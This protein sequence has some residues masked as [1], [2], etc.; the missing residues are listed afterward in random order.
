MLLIITW[1]CHIHACIQG[2]Q[3]A[4]A[5]QTHG[6]LIALTMLGFCMQDDIDE[7]NKIAHSLKARLDNLARMN[8]AA[9]KRKV[10]LCTLPC[11]SLELQLLP[12]GG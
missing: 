3:H 10:C 1:I 7:V 4:L 5:L 12:K 9:L 2:V 8:E 11:I 6:H